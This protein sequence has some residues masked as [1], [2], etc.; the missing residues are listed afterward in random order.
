M[1]CDFIKAETGDVQEKQAVNGSIFLDLWVG[2]GEGLEQDGSEKLR[3]ADAW[4]GREGV[5]GGWFGVVEVMGFVLE[6]GFVLAGC[7]GLVF[8]EG[9]FIAVI[10][11]EIF[12]VAAADAIAV[13]SFTLLGLGWHFVVAA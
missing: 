9:R 7:L 1:F 3:D 2:I 6:E 13:I 8:S 11:V 12:D 4:Q 5:V 10:A